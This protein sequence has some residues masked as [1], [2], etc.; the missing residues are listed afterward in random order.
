M[1]LRL[2]Q[3]LYFSENH[4]PPHPMLRCYVGLLLS[5]IRV[6]LGVSYEFST[7][8]S[9][10]LGRMSYVWTGPVGLPASATELIELRPLILLCLQHGKPVSKI[11][12]G[13]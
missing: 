10:C 9:W 6:D 8:P 5:Q 1:Y 2:A 13:G 12:N 4:K 11:I 7:T 3:I